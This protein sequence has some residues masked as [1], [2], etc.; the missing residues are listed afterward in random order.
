MKKN[1]KWFLAGAGVAVAAAVFAHK[2]YLNTYVKVDE[3]EDIEDIAEE[4]DFVPME[5]IDDGFDI[6]V[7]ETYFEE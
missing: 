6:E 3:A 4:S 7:D 5:E 2:K 1:M